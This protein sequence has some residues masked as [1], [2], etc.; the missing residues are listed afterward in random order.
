VEALPVLIST[1]ARLVADVESAIERRLASLATAPNAASALARG[2]AVVPASMDEAIATSDRLAPE[3]L[4]IVTADPDSVATRCRH[5]G[6][7]FIGALTA[8]VA[9]DYGAG[10][11]HTLP[12]GGGARY[13]GGLSVLDFLRQRTWMRMDDPDT[14]VDLYADAAEMAAIE[15]LEAHRE[16]AELRKR[17]SWP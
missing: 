10:P 16:A 3:H 8:E 1:S 15:G 17:G 7:V 13:T 9:G 14:A 6:A 2:F 4:Q 5:Y 11:N 12:T